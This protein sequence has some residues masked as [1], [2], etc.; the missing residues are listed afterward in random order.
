MYERGW[1]HICETWSLICGMSCMSE[2]VIGLIAV[3]CV[4]GSYGQKVR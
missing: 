1:G 3:L 4:F 2:I